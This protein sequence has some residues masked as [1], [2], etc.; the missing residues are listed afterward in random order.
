MNYVR[1]TWA[2]PS[3]SQNEL[4]NCSPLD[5]TKQ[6]S[7]Y[8]SVPHSCFCTIHT[9]ATNSI[10][11]LC[12]CTHVISIFCSSLHRIFSLWSYVQWCTGL[13]HLAI[14]SS[15]HVSKTK[16]K[17]TFKDWTL[18]STPAPDMDVSMIWYN[19]VVSHR[20]R[21]LDRP[22]FHLCNTIIII[23]SGSTAPVG[24]WPPF[25]QFLKHI[26]GIR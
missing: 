4:F 7:P 16:L 19:H 15:A 8:M 3:P 20:E 1:C 23:I 25:I 18:S 10:L 24:P 2:G 21:L 5:R 6:R 9:L 17:V 14:T 22:I 11:L 12:Y 13:Q 26:Y